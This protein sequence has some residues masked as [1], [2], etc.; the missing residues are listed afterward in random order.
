METV[1]PKEL[2]RSLIEQKPEPAFFV[3][4]TAEDMHGDSIRDS[5]PIF[6]KDEEEARIIFNEL[7][8]DSTEI[9]HIKPA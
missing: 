2:W 6:A 9:R 8:A 3:S 7:S 4:Y 1:T 5:L